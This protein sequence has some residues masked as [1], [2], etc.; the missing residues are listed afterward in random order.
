MRLS[1]ATAL[2]VAPTVASAQTCSSLR[3]DRADLAQQG[4]QSVGKMTLC[5]KMSNFVAHEYI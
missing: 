2:L 1:V 3:S 4:R 5:N